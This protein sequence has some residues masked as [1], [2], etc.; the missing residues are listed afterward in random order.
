M[1]HTLKFIATLQHIF[2]GDREGPQRNPL[3]A[4]IFKDT[5]HC[6]GKPASSVILEV[7][8]KYSFLAAALKAKYVIEPSTE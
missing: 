3:C 4:K 1:A 6:S 2:A 5:G 7:A 8:E